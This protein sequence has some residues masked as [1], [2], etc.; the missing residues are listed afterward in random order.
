MSAPRARV[1]ADYPIS[2]SS[3]PVYSVVFKP[4]PHDCCRSLP[5]R[6]PRGWVEC[7]FGTRREAQAEA[8]AMN[9]RGAA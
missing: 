5:I 6:H 8:D 1:R 3:R 4:C 7:S 2:A 9:R